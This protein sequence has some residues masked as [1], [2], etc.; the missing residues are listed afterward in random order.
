MQFFTRCHHCDGFMETLI[1]Q[2]CLRCGR[3]AGDETIAS[4]LRELFMILL[5]WMILIG[6]WLFIGETVIQA[7][8]AVFQGGFVM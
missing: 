4:Y 3:M 7:L 1:D 2:K 5:P 8:G 6:V